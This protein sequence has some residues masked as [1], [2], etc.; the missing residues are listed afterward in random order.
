MKNLQSNYFVL[1]I[2]L[3]VLIYGCKKDE[4]E[5]K[6]FGSANTVTITG[7]ILDQNNVAISEATLVINEKSY[8]TNSD[9][10]YNIKLIQAPN[11]KVSITYSKNG[12]ISLTRNEIVGQSINIK[13]SLIALSSNMVSQTT[14]SAEQG[15]TV[16]NFD[17]SFVH[18]PA[19]NYKDVNGN[20]YNGAVKVQMISINPDNSNFS[21]MIDGSS[22]M[23]DEY[24]QYLE[25]FGVMRVELHDANGNEIIYNSDSSY[26]KSTGASIGVTIPQSKVAD[27][28][29]SI[30]LYSYDN[31]KSAY[32]ATG[33]ATKNGAGQ[34]VGSVQHFSSWTCAEIGSAPSQGSAQYTI[35]GGIYTNQT[36]SLF[37]SFYAFY[38]VDTTG[39]GSNY[40]YIDCS[41]SDGYFFMSLDNV[42][43][44][45]SY[46]ITTGVG[47]HF[48][49]PGSS[50]ITMQSGTIIITRYDSVGGLIEG[51]FSGTCIDGTYTYTVSNGSF[52]MIR[53]A[54][55]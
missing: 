19:N 21:Q 51:T 14:F 7:K 35:D 2:S 44:V 42:Q 36:F 3:I 30:T 26:Y 10:E 38:H 37:D 8:I 5:V 39:S 47:A 27:A 15:T 53:S 1:F 6:Y 22:Y 43:S 34:Y 29:Q 17:G 11:T 4:Q 45:G 31:T 28:P 50:Q 46:T 32:V 20:Q 18:L 40:T 33:T 12:Y 13:V 24:G 16:T 48:S 52:S 25:S 23:V 9:G 54:N 49:P 55:Q 41:G